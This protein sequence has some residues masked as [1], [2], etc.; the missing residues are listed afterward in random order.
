VVDAATRREWRELG[1]WYDH[2][3][4]A[5]ER[6]LAGDRIRIAEEYAGPGSWS[7]VLEI[8]EDGCDPAALD[9]LLPPPG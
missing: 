6:R 8:R 7:L 1:F 9:P 4:A 2:D 5:R 3:E